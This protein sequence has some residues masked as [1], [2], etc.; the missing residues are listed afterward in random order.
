MEED[1][2]LV[3]GEGVVDFL[4]PYDAAAMRRYVHHLKPECVSHQVVRQHHG[5]LQAGVGPSV[6]VRIGNVQLGDGDGEDLVRRLGD[7]ALHRLLILVGENGRHGGV[8]CRLE[9]G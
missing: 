6:L 2:V 8:L 4:V 9:V 5:T 1:A 7:G 3:V